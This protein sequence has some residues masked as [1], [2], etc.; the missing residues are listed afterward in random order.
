MHHPCTPARFG[1]AAAALAI[2]LL[3]APAAQACQL[4][5]LLAPMPA[6]GVADDA[7]CNAAYKGF[8]LAK[9]GVI[10]NLPGDISSFYGAAGGPAC[11][12]PPPTTDTKAAIDYLFSKLSTFGL[13]SGAVQTNC[14]VP[15][16]GTTYCQTILTSSPSS[17]WPTTSGV[18]CPGIG[19]MLCCNM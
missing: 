14:S 4:V 19:K 18:P 9:D 11:G 17:A 7:A 3:A 6:S 2:G 15:G 13:G 10:A 16:P 5:C 1:L 8:K 12:G